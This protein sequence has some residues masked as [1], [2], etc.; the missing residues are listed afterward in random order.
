[1]NQNDGRTHIQYDYL[2]AVEK[3]QKEMNHGT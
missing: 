2:E 3:A 1:M